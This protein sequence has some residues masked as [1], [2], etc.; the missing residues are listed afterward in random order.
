ML[1]FTQGLTSVR[2]NR[3]AY[4][5]ASPRLS[6]LIS[7]KFII[8]KHPFLYYEIKQ[9]EV[10]TEDN[11]LGHLQQRLSVLDEEAE[12][13]THYKDGTEY[14]VR[15]IFYRLK[16]HVDRFLEGEDVENVDIIPG[17]RGVGKTTLFYQL[18]NEFKHRFEQGNI[19]YLTCDQINHYLDSSLNEALDVYE[20]RILGKNIE[21][22][23]SE[24]L[25]FIDEAHYQDN[26]AP[27]IK[28]F[29]DRSDKVMV[30]VTGSSSISLELSTD[31]SRRANVETLYPLR[32]FEYE[33]FKNREEEGETVSPPRNLSQNLFK[34]CFKDVSGDPDVRDNLIDKH[35]TKLRTQYFTQFGNDPE[36]ELEKFLLNG[37]FPFCLSKRRE[38]V[39]EDIFEVL[40]R[41]TT[42]DLEEFTNLGDKALKK[43]I[44]VLNLIA[45][46]EDE[47]SLQSITQSLEGISK[48]RVGDI[49]KAY[50]R[51]GVL[52]VAEPI[53]T[54]EQIQSKASKYFF[55]SPTIQ[56]SLLWNMGRMNRDNET[57]GSLLETEVAGQLFRR[58]KTNEET[59]EE[60]FYDYQDGGADFV[61]KLSRGEKCVIEVGWGDK[62]S[63]GVNQVANTLENV[64]GD[65][66]LVV[67]SSD[68]DYTEVEVDGETKPVY[69]VPKQTFVML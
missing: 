4:L 31:L 68:S 34:A 12:R 1:Y 42:E 40:N 66:G 30:I 6:D 9:G 17:L 7:C 3:V 64:G 28:S 69:F 54:A 8:L 43:A 19:L 45:G 47:I 57:L 25:I 38:E 32:F 29:A 46:A 27:I 37:G 20:K 41:V 52:H 16:K 61:V 55:S 60:V 49:I 39:Y 23:D 22:L 58:A 44:P 35:S 36:I 53:G 13:K 33:L 62:S 15:P 21:N 18:Y 67:N 56:A 14:A 24:V 63:K 51:A 26:W 59:I 10:M 65:Y 50:Q 48:S 2:L 11:V 5:A